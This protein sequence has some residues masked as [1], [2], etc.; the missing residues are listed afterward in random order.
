MDGLPLVLASAGSYLRQTSL[1][2]TEYLRLYEQS[3]ICLHETTSRLLSYRD[4]TL[5][6]TWSLSITEIRKKN[7]LSSFILDIWACFDSQDLWCELLQ[8]HDDCVK[9]LLNGIDP[10]SFHEAM[11]V[12]CDYG[13][14]EVNPKPRAETFESR[15]YRMHR[16]V[17]SWLF[18]DFNHVSKRQYVNL[19]LLCVS[20]H[21]QKYGGLRKRRNC[22]RLLPHVNQLIYFI[23]GGIMDDGPM[24]LFEV[25]CLLNLT[26]LLSQASF[27]HS[28]PMTV[29][30]NCFF[31]K[32]SGTPYIWAADKI[33]HIVLSKVQD[34]PT[35]GNEKLKFWAYFRITEFFL[36]TWKL[37][38]IRTAWLASRAVQSV[39]GLQL[40]K[41]IMRCG[42]V[43][44]IGVVLLMPYVLLGCI[45]LLAINPGLS[46]KDLH[47]VIDLFL[48][49]AGTGSLVRW[50]HQLKVFLF[51]I[52]S[53]VLTGLYELIY[54]GSL[55]RIYFQL[56]TLTLMGFCHFS[57][58]SEMI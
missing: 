57:D 16:C 56:F 7:P 8:Q 46:S 18:H 38:S 4:K 33:A 39:P 6:S 25:N 11:R 23:D 43:C 5:W 47:S 37:S 52:L 14:A 26:E 3:W 28:F 15:G 12:L 27:Y 10:L 48:L 55:G 54:A 36:S 49:V 13:M 50:K 35:E 58:R 19:A 24:R 1:T 17:H 34:L 2:C 44:V 30:L 9:T 41:S 31:I 32:H 53:M 40:E 42:G 29:Y 20:K 21:G 22:Y 45:L 51:V